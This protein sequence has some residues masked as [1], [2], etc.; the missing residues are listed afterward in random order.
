MKKIILPLYSALLTLAL[1]L[2]GCG[3]GN[4]VRLLPLPPLE[5]PTLPAPNAPSVSVVNFEDARIDE[6]VLGARRDGSAFIAEGDVPSWISRALADELARNGLRVTFAATTSQARSGNPDFMVTGKVDEV[7]LKENSATSFSVTMRVN[8]TLA[9]R[10][11]RI[12][13][14]SCNSSQT[15]SSLP[16]GAVADD[17]MLDTLRDLVK[18]IALKIIQSI[19]AKK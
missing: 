17:L 16:S 7:W 13:S 3:P 4:S 2:Y 6:A 9:N 1:C 12:W 18:P 15:I 19:D 5:S 10:K 8:C 14:E 11:G